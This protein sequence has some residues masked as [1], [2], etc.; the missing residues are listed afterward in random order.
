MRCLTRVRGKLAWFPT[1][2]IDLALG[3]KHDVIEPYMCMGSSYRCIVACVHLG[4]GTGRRTVT[5][6]TPLLLTSRPVRFE[7]VLHSCGTIPVGSGYRLVT[8]CSYRDIIVQPH[9]NTMPLIS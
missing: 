3:T 2:F 4:N 9:W 7:A 8:I 6:T 5:L 1:L